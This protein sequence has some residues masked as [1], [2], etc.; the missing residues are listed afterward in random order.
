M[1]YAGQTWRSIKTRLLEHFAYRRSEKNVV[2]DNHSVDVERSEKSN[3]N[4]L[5][6]NEKESMRFVPIV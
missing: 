2:G 1:W 6:N 3:I 5:M 4:N